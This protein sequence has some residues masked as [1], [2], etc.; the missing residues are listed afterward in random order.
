[1]KKTAAGPDAWAPSEL[2][3][4]PAAALAE[5]ARLLEAAE[6]TAQWPTSLLQWRQV[7]IPK[8]GRPAG[9]LDSLRPISVAFYR[10]WSHIRM[11]QLGS[12]IAQNLPRE[13]HGGIRKKGVHSALILPL[14]NLEKAQPC[15]RQRR[16]GPK[17]LGSA[18]LSK[19]FDALAA[20]HAVCSL[21]RM[22]VPKRLCAALLAAWKGQ[23]RLL[24]LGRHAG[25]Q[26]LSNVS[27]LP[28]G[29][30][31][32]VLGL[33]VCISEALFSIKRTSQ[34]ARSAFHSCFLDDRTWF[35]EKASSCVGI[36][37]A[38]KQEMR[39]LGLKENRTKQDFAA[40]GNKKG[41][42]SL[43]SELEAQA[44]QGTV[45]ARPKVLGTTAASSAQK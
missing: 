3:H 35:T 30:P 11:K 18:D 25:E 26:F 43:A 6:E 40:L 23:Q 41:R 12:W 31:A 27:C 32:S 15:P 21:E 38:W 4:L 5:A 1:M 20:E 24:Q 14:A 28:Q 45:C 22:R 29:D 8:P 16:P 10:A 9:A 44:V 42:E 13:L 17:C 2:Q 37:A 39:L 33:N 34:D 19:A 36:G 7:A